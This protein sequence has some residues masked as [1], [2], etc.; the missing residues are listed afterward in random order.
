MEQKHILK[1][2]DA[3]EGQGVGREREMENAR[4]GG[5]KG[6]DDVVGMVALFNGYA[7][8]VCIDIL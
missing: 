8:R 1:Q 4:D 5:S 6:C 7:V 2:P 3:R